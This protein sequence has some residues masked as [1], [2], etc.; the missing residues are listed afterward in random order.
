ME[1]PENLR[2]FAPDP[3]GDESYP[4]VTMTW[5]LVYKNYSDAK[6]AMALRDLLSWCLSNG[7]QE[8]SR[9]G[10]VPL[11]S[12]VAGKSLAALQTIQPR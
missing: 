7:Q 2:A 8:A 10:Y 6:K 1:I 4:I 3:A 12:N 11:P 5:I 9:L